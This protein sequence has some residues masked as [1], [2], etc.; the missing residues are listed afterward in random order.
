MAK[1]KRKAI[2]GREPKRVGRPRK[3]AA[4][5]M[6][7]MSVSVPI[8]VREVI[9]RLCDVEEAGR[10]AVVG[11]LIDRALGS[12]AVRKKLEGGGKR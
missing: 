7:P 1:K 5:C 3:N 4:D 2:A 12:A 8:K 6:V 11:D 10:S 9:D